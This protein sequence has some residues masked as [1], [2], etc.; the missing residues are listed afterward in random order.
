MLA[1]TFAIWKLIKRSNEQLQWARKN[2]HNQFRW[3]L[4][5]PVRCSVQWQWNLIRINDVC[6]RISAADYSKYAKRTHRTT[7]TNMHTNTHTLCMILHILR[8]VNACVNGREWNA[9]GEPKKRQKRK[10][11][12]TK[13]QHQNVRGL[14]SWLTNCYWYKRGDTR[15]N[16]NSS[17]P[18]AVDRFCGTW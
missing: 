7:N 1:Y 5:L 15:W 2:V 12:V 8:C 10:K 13:N 11:N 9:K 14:N 16:A 3:K 17:I 18:L 4:N 6:L